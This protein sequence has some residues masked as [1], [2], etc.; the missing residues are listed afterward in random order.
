MGCRINNNNQLGEHMGH[1]YFGRQQCCVNCS[2]GRHLNLDC[3]LQQLARSLLK[4]VQQCD[5]HGRP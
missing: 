2:F 4:A 5:T 3:C 1:S